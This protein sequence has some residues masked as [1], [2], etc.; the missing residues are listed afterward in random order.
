MEN[1]GEHRT[2]HSGSTKGAE[3]LHQLNDC[4]LFKKESASGREKIS[5]I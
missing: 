1:S 2:K 4:K 5:E 3:F